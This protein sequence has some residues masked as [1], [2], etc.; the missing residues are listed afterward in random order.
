MELRNRVR[1]LV[2]ERRDELKRRQP[3]LAPEQL[4]LEARPALILLDYLQLMSS[5]TP[6]E[7]RVQEISQISRE[8]KTI[9]RE[10]GCPL[11]ALSQLSRNV[12]QRPNKR[13][14]NSDLRESGAIE[15]DADVI[16]F[17]YRDEVYHEDT[18]DKG[19][20]EIIIGKQRNGPIGS[21]RLAFVG[22]HT[23]FENLARDY[24]AE[25]R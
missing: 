6:T 2:R 19:I 9:A 4:D 15:Q 11:V 10:F 3:E 5:G 16:V 8:L 20:A 24:F 22:K 7:G 14:I 13:P 23:R 12:E 17:I 25:E 1:R 18:Q 21:A